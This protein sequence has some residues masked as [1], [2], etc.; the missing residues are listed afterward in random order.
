M[1]VLVQSI[2]DGLVFGAIYAI[3]GLTFG[4]IY[5]VT[6]VFHIAFGS[7]GTLGTY[8]A[9]AL[10]GSNGSLA[11]IVSSVALGALVAGAATVAVVV[12]VYRPLIRRGADSGATFVS[13]LGLA[14]LIEALVILGFGANDRSFSV[15]SFVRRHDVGGFGI[16]NFHVVG[17]GLAVVVVIALILLVDHTRFGHQLRAVASSREQADLVGIR[18]GVVATTACALAGALSV[19]AFVLVGMNGAVVATGGTQLTLFAVLAVIA[20][21]VG[22]FWGTAILG[23]ALGVLSGVSGTV[24]PGQWSATAVFV[25]AL[26]LILL[27]PRGLASRTGAPT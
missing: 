21:G 26:V 1:H 9:V 24:F 2:I 19:I 23:F 3:A 10:A 6:K 12:L 15:D 13:S 17:V 27:R 22:R 8:V 4:L 11:H 16:S 7:I 20:G 14:T 25:C 18:S 5:D